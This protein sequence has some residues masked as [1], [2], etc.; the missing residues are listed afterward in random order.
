MTKVNVDKLSIKPEHSVFEWDGNQGEWHLDLPPLEERK[1]YF[2]R[3]DLSYQSLFIPTLPEPRAQFMERCNRAM[4]LFHERH[5]FRPR[6]V[7]IIVSHAA[8]CVALAKVL[9]KKNLNDITPAGPCSIYGFTRKSSSGPVWH[10]DLH[11]NLDG[12]NGYT[13]HLSDQGSTTV[14]WNDFGDGKTKFYTGP[15]TSRFA[16]KS[17]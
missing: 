14:P 13:G 16:P 10:L 6:Q 8:G 12:F 2:P 1:H 3:L 15:P 9:S 17:P 7:F 5:P 4:N 11:D